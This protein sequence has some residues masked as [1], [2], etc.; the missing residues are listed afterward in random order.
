MNSWMVLSYRIFYC[1][2]KSFY[3]NIKIIVDEED[4]NQKQTYCKTKI[5]INPFKMRKEFN[6]KKIFEMLQIR[7]ISNKEA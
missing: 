2:R 5:T 3:Q 7:V 6:P 4:R 1:F